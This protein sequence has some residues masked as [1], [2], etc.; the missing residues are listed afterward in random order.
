MTQK[1]TEKKSNA[2]LTNLDSRIGDSMRRNRQSTLD[3]YGMEASPEWVGDNR[4]TIRQSEINQSDIDR[5]NQL[6]GKKEKRKQR[7][8]KTIKKGLEY[9]SDVDIKLP[10][11]KQPQPQPT[12][13]FPTEINVRFEEEYEKPTPPYGRDRLPH[14]NLFQA[15]KIHQPEP[16]PIVRVQPSQI[17]ILRP[18]IRRH[19]NVR[20][21]YV[22]R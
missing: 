2:W 4:K 15:N 18:P 8:S 5:L 16:M 3:E 6:L 7:I 21:P 11:H 17:Y 22:R 1:K 13:S 9:A 10:S 14:H 19:R 20:T 12:T